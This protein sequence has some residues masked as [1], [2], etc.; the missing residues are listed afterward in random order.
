[1][2]DKCSKTT[3]TLLTRVKKNSY[4]IGLLGG[5]TVFPNLLI[6]IPEMFY[7]MTHSRSLSDHTCL[8]RELI[9]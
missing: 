5:K 3:K 2:V 8:F 7:K 4:Q 9:W 1:M 6:K